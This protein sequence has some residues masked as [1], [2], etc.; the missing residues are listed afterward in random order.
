[1]SGKPV[2]DHTRVLAEAS[3]V[4]LDHNKI[5]REKQRILYDNNTKLI[6][7]SE[8]DYMNIKEIA[9][10]VRK[11]KKFRDRWR[12]PFLITKKSLFVTTKFH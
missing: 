3:K 7:F 9:I 4:V 5:C 6:T 1:M 12:G 8:E 10:G 2:D 11:S